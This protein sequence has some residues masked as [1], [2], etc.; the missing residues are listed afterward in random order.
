MAWSW[1]RLT[2][3]PDAMGLTSFN[4]VVPNN[5]SYN[6]GRLGFDRRQNFQ[7]NWSY[8]IPGLGQKMHSKILGAVVDHWTLSGHL[9][10]PERSAVQSRIQHRQRHAGLHR[11]SRR[12]ARAST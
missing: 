4:P 3:G 10:D 7:F 8:D 5:A 2:R 1:V 6:Y 12:E 9:V 11:D